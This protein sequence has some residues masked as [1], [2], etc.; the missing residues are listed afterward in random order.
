MSKV[1]EF[2]TRVQAE[3]EERAVGVTKRVTVR[4]GP[5]AY[6]K[7]HKTADELGMSVTGCAQ[8]LLSAAVDEAYE[9]VGFLGVDE[10]E[11]LELMLPMVDESERQEA[12]ETWGRRIQATEVTRKLVGTTEGGE[13]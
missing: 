6:F 1:G 12:L 13:A 11:F 3:R 5:F 2:V 8:E 10:E 9:R 7:L 4:L